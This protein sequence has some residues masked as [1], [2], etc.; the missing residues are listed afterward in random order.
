MF[1]YCLRFDSSLLTKYEHKPELH[2]LFDRQAFEV[3]SQVDAD[4]NGLIDYEEVIQYFFALRE[5]YQMKNKITSW[6]N[7]GTS[8]YTGIDLSYVKK[9]YLEIDANEDGY[10]QPEEFDRDLS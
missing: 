2:D 6:K 9:Y 1:G 3:F 5:K 7:N 10:I 8:L 4:A